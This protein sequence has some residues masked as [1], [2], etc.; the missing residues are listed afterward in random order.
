M[1]KGK[2]SERV[3]S[4]VKYAVT[5]DVVP[6]PLCRAYSNARGS[7][8]AKVLQIVIRHVSVFCREWW[9]IGYAKRSGQPAQMMAEAAKK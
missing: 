9:R 3:G 7:D 5:P 2:H 8:S 1:V 4:S 6:T